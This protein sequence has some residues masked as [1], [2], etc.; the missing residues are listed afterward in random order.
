[1]A[2]K[3]TIQIK[4]R[5]TAHSNKRTSIIPIDIW[6]YPLKFLRSCTI[7]VFV[8]AN[9]QPRD[10]LYILLH[11]SKSNIISL[12]WA[13]EPF[14]VSKYCALIQRSERSVPGLLF[15]VHFQYVFYFATVSA[16]VIQGV[17]QLLHV[18]FQQPQPRLQIGVLRFGV[19]STSH[20]YPGYLVI[21]LKVDH[22]RSQKWAELHEFLFA[23]TNYEI[24]VDRQAINGFCNY[25]YFDRWVV[26]KSSSWYKY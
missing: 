17:Q 18:F 13:F 10:N 20:T 5:C 1:L 16:D 2:F 21:V 12:W 11:W 14:S 24:V 6:L 26:F 9:A 3:N 15:S 7:Y 19:I 4:Y 23:P 8:L 25:T 22:V